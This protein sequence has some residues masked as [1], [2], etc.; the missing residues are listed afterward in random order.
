MSSPSK[1][2]PKRRRP[3]DRSEIRVSF[4]PE[5]NRAAKWAYVCMLAGLV[6][7]VGVLTGFAA[8]ILG[9]FGRRIA[10][11]DEHERGLGHACMSMIL[12]AVEVVCQGIGW[13]LLLD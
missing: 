6:P 9:F 2:K 7:G 5:G 13:W 8:I 11:K 12:G 4:L 3:H 1:P 10:K